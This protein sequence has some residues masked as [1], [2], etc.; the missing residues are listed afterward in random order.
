METH[1]GRSIP[2]VKDF[3]IEGSWAPA[4]P[5]KP[6]GSRP[7]PIYDDGQGGLLAQAWGEQ[8]SYLPRYTQQNDPQTLL[9]YSISSAERGSYPTPSNNGWGGVHENPSLSGRIQLERQNGEIQRRGLEEHLPHWSSHGRRS[10]LNN[11]SH[12]G[13][14]NYPRFSSWDLPL[15]WNHE[16]GSENG[17]TFNSNL[18]GSLGEFDT[19]SFGDLLGING[20]QTLLNNGCVFNPGWVSQPEASR[21]NNVALSRDQGPLHGINQR[22][23]GLYERGMSNGALPQPFWRTGNVNLTPTPKHGNQNTPETPDSRQRIH[24]LG[25]SDKINPITNQGLKAKNIHSIPETP[26]SQQRMQR[27]GPSDNINPGTNQGLKAQNDLLHEHDVAAAMVD[28]QAR[29]Q[30]RA[31]EPVIDSIAE[32]EDYNPEKEAIPGIDLNKTPQKKPRRRRYQPKVI[33]E[34]KPKRTPKPKTPNPT[35]SRDAQVKRKSARKSKQGPTPTTPSEEAAEPKPTEPPSRSCKKSLNFDLNGEQPTN[36]RQESDNSSHP[37][38]SMPEEGLM[39][40]KPMTAFDLNH[41]MSQELSEYMSLPVREN[42]DSSQTDMNTKSPS[43]LSRKT[44]T[45]VTKTD[46]H[47]APTSNI[48][49]SANSS[50]GVQTRG[51]KRSLSYTADPIYIDD[52]IRAITQSARWQNNYTCPKNTHTEILPQSFIPDICKKKRTEKIQ[53][54]HIEST[55]SSKYYYGNPEPFGVNGMTNNQAVLIN[56]AENREQFSGTWADLSRLKKKRTK[57]PTRVRDLALF[58]GIASVGEGT[59]KTE[60]NMRSGHYPCTATSNDVLSCT[61]ALSADTR[62]IP[63]SKRSSEKQY[64]VNKNWNIVLYDSNHPTKRATDSIPVLP[65]RKRSSTIEHVTMLFQRLDINKKESKISS[66]EKAIV[67]YD[68]Q[69]KNALVLYE[70]DGSIVP[71]EGLFDPVRKRRQRARVDLDDETSRV[72]RLLLENID[73]EGIDG[74]DEDKAK[75]WDNERRVFRGR[76]D[77]FI[78]RMRLVQGDRRFTP[79]KGSVLDS[80][81]GVFLTQNV[82]DHLSSSAF[83]SMAAR[84]PL[85]PESSGSNLSEASSS[86]SV[87]PEPEFCIFEP[88]ESVIWNEKAINQPTLDRESRVIYH[89]DHGEEKELCQK[90]GPVGPSE[91]SGETCQKPTNNSRAFNANSQNIETETPYILRDDKARDDASSSPQSVISPQNS[92]NSTNLQTASVVQVETTSAKFYNLESTA[93]FVGLLKMAECNSQAELQDQLE[94]TKHV[95]EYYGAPGVSLSDYQLN[96]EAGFHLQYH[97]GI[98]ILEVES[99]SSP[100]SDKDE[101]SPTEQSSLTSEITDQEKNTDPISRAAP[102]MSW[103]YVLEGETMV[104]KSEME[105]VKEPLDMHDITESTRVFKRAKEQD[106]KVDPIPEQS[107]ASGMLSD[108]VNTDPGI[109]GKRKSG[110]AKKNEFEWDSLRREA[111][112]NGKR[113]EKTANTMDSLDWEAVRHAD[114]SEIAETIKERGMNNMLAER[115]KGLLD[116]LVKDH[117]SINMEWLRD[118]PPDKAKEYLLSFRGLGLKSVECVRLLTLH[119]LAFPVDTNVGRIAVRLGWVPLQPLPESLQLHLLE[120]YPILESIQ[121][122][123]WPR[124]CKLDQKTLYELHY[125]MITFGKVFCTKRQPNCNACPLRAECRHF[126]SAFASARFS[127]PGP[128]ERSIVP[129]S[130]TTTPN[131]NPRASINLLL[132]TDSWANH[133]SHSNCKSYDAP[134]N[135]VPSLP[136]LLPFPQDVHL[137]RKSINSKCEPI[138]EVPASPEQE[139]QHEQALCDIEDAF[140]ED[141]NEIPTINLNMKEFTQTLQ[142]FMEANRDLQEA[143]VSNALVALAPEAASIPT[144]KLK[145]IN[146][147]RTEHYVYELPDTHPLLHG[148]EKREPDDPCSYLLAIWTP[149]ETANSI[150]PPAR[151]CSFNDPS[152]LCN[153]ETCSYCSS[154]RETDSQI[155][156]GTLLIPTRTAMRGSFPLNGTYFQVN[157]VFADHDSSLTPIAVPRSWLWNLPR[158]TVYFGTSIPT[159]FKGLTTEDI[160]HCFWRGYVCVRGFDQKTRAPRPLM[161][162]LHFPASRSRGYR[163]K[164]YDE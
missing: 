37:V 40:K 21:L 14:S 106:K 83:M 121:K 60:V 123:L 43:S 133:D 59:R 142:N 151:K 80:V 81:I 2:A 130:G 79:W 91:C 11:G 119:H 50:E 68:K 27:Q 13:S 55:S 98:E 131:V 35:D 115:I 112:V 117:G 46:S 89:I 132:S 29:N 24:R 101:N 109:T 155:V 116:R 99:R 64:S 136:L 44:A 49:T 56:R 86:L 102:N 100:I 104:M 70:K 154:Q 85:K 58:T 74:T 67:P 17:A 82:S 1:R 111:E 76:V 41:T 12:L 7:N 6:N 53:R 23:D 157:E 63:R 146:R 18:S 8:G 88:E 75:W 156:R 84:F 143:E 9:S 108:K 45:S 48:S 39:L 90:A 160:Q 54:L 51:S 145:N 107:Y 5:A 77:S 114:V 3:H 31:S 138:V 78:A 139:P 30:N 19:M 96:P 36:E 153:E 94:G 141:P 62:A 22:T 149:G 92:I 113:P 163:S 71:Y 148:L 159:I 28:L 65:W 32:D 97:K 129:S 38:Y 150:D 124:L 122:Y 95:T 4:T 47:L 42:L 33:R 144:P 61:E 93:S 135:Q 72:W 87:E 16:G 140:Y 120:M 52:G 110:K 66:K 137:E 134:T 20:S 164:V 34:N 127:L 125:H 103:C 73:N 161:A 69:D 147:L 118:I 10:V 57:G 25:P 105:K 158:R 128:E 15:P 126:A 26:D 162:R 152:M